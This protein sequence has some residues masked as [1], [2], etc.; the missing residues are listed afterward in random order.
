MVR[1]VSLK[2]C[3]LVM[4]FSWIAS[5]AEA[6]S[7]CGQSPSS[8]L[9]LRNYQTWFSGF[10]YGYTQTLGRL[11]SDGKAFYIWPEEKKQITHSLGLNVAHSFYDHW[12]WNLKTSYLQRAYEDGGGSE[13]ASGWGDSLVSFTYEILPLYTY[14]PWKPLVYLSFFLNIP[15][16]HSPYE[17]ELS[18]EGTSV[19]GYGQWGEGLGVTLFKVFGQSKATLQWKSMYYNQERFSETVVSNFFENGFFAQWSISTPL[20]STELSLGYRWSE[21]GKRN[22]DGIPSENSLSNA[23]ELGLSRSIYEN[24][25]LSFNFSDETLLGRSRNTLLGRNYAATFSYQV[26]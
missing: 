22:V 2:I 6:S 8:F 20:L 13:Q 19:T 17:G 15:T 11:H 18:E 7:C 5:L 4:A 26:P 25:F 16:G 23:I 12:Q 24:Y 3:V 10:T 9:V 21:L 14:S 1:R